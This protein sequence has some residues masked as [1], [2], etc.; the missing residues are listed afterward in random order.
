MYGKLSR[1]KKSNF[2]FS[3][4]GNHSEDGAEGTAK[5][6]EEVGDPMT[7]ITDKDRHPSKFVVRRI[8]RLIRRFLAAVPIDLKQPRH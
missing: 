5:W 1:K 8:Q 2:V 4:N 6:S 3:T 7:P